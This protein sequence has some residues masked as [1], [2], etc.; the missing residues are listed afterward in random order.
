[1]I[2]MASIPADRTATWYKGTHG[3]EYFAYQNTVGQVYAELVRERFQQHV[4]PTDVVIDFGCGGGWL[5]EML[6]AATKIGIEVNESARSE[7]IR[8]SIH[9]V[10]SA[11][12]LPAQSADLVISNH[13]LEHTLSPFEELRGLRRLLKPTGKLVLWLPFNDWRVER[14]E[15]IDREH[16]LYTWT[17]YLLRNLLREAGF[18]VDEC[19]VVTRFWPVLSR[20]APYGPRI[21]ITL[22]RWLPRLLAQSLAVLCAMFHQQ[23]EVVAVASV[24]AGQPCG[25][26]PD[27][28]LPGRS[29]E[30]VR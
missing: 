9:T 1:M 11:E 20:F 19:R 10:V 26:T 6:N 28:R 7:A 13:V 3:D 17:P 25:G 23:R 8:R 18:Q 22:W 4:K 21:S 15:V 5:L 14:T 12:Q 2:S 29:P 27:S 30:S 16:H 24:A